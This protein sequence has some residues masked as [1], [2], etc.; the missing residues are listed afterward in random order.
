M[1]KLIFL[2]VL[3]FVF[4]CGKEKVKPEYTFTPEEV[5][6]T[7]EANTLDTDLPDYSLL[8][9]VDISLK[10]SIEEYD[11][12]IN[13]RFIFKFLVSDKIRREQIEPLFTKL[14]KDITSLDNDIDDITISLYSD[15]SLVNGG[16]DIAMATWA[17]ANGEVTDE[18]AL[19]NNRETYK[20]D[21]II[22]ENLEEYLANKLIKSDKFG[23][24]Q[25]KRKQ[26]SIEIG[27]SEARANKD[28]DKLFPRVNA[29]NHEKYSNKLYELIEK[30]KQ[31]IIKKHNINEDIYFSIMEEGIEKRWE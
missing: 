29:N 19:N 8:K 11:A 1:K 21:I 28:A 12:P 23:L 17:P 10:T 9:K 15:K 13:K 18:I 2:A 25:D 30:Y 6:Q 16:Y 20:I 31:E 3:I 4:S 27:D 22:A 7:Q 24:S 5:N 14:L 26:I